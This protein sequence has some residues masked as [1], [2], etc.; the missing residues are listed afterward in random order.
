MVHL[1]RNDQA[2]DGRLC[3]ALYVTKDTRVLLTS[4]ADAPWI[5]D[6]QIPQLGFYVKDRNWTEQPEELASDLCRGRQVVSDTGVANTKNID[7]ELQKLRVRLSP[8]EQSLARTLGQDLTSY[9][10]RSA[11]KIQPGQTELEVAGAVTHRLMAAGIEPVGVWVSGDG[12]NERY[13]ESIPGS[14]RID[15]FATV[16]ATG[17]RDGVCLTVSRILCF[18]IPQQTVPPAYQAADISQATGIYWSQPEMMLEKIW[19]RVARSYEV[20]GFSEEWRLNEQGGILAQRPCEH[21]IVPNG[22]LRLKPGMLVNWK[23]QVGPCSLSDTILVTDDG[24]EWL[25]KTGHWPLFEVEIKG[26]AISRP[27]LLKL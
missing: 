9:V 16:T 24:P 5:F 21:R 15:R 19:E 26:E 13:Q 23:S 2:P 4:N 11:L 6:T 10:E 8:R 14:N 12:Q 17:R 22:P 25:T 7:N 1:G 18:E 3:A 20:N 27:A